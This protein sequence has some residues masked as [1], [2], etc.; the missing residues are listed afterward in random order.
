M[1]NSTTIRQLQK[2]N[3]LVASITQQLRRAE[4]IRDALVAKLADSEGL[5]DRQ[6]CGVR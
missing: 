4:A 5:H 1:N 6:P 3:E 2:A